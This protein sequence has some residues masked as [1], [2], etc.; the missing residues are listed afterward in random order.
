M[1]DDQ[2]RERDEHKRIQRTEQSEGV[3]GPL[4]A[5]S[6]SVPSYPAS[7]LSDPRLNGRG[8]GPV[9]TALMR[10]MQQTYGNR[11]VQ[12]FLQR[13]KDAA[14]PDTTPP[15]LQRNQTKADGPS[16]GNA[17]AQEPAGQTNT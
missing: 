12:R 16:G 13:A 8:N 9:R 6:E 14:T 11:A 4:A 2:G 17:T 10:Q 15:Q 1:A 7:L 3:Q 5:E